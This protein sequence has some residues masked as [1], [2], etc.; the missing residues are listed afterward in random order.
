TLFSRCSK[1]LPNKLIASTRSDFSDG[2]ARTTRTH[3]YN[4]AV[5]TFLLSSV[6]VRT[7]V[8][9]SLISSATRSEFVPSTLN[10]RNNPTCKNG[11]L[12]PPTSYS[13]APAPNN[14]RNCRTIIGTNLRTFSKCSGSCCKISTTIAVI[15]SCTP[16]LL[17]P[18]N[19]RARF[20]NNSRLSG[21]R[22][23][24]RSPVSTAFLRI[25]DR[26]DPISLNTSSIK[27]RAISSVPRTDSFLRATAINDPT[28]V[29]IILGLTS[30]ISSGNKNIVAPS[31][32]AI[33]IAYFEFSLMSSSVTPIVTSA[34]STIPGFIPSSTS[35][36]NR[37][38]FSCESL[39]DRIGYSSSSACSPPSSSASKHGYVLNN[40]ATNAK[41]NLGFPLT[42]VFADTYRRHPIASAPSNIA[43]ALCVKSPILIAD[44]LHTSGLNW[45]SNTI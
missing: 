15:P 28:N 24:N 25:N 44:V 7:C 8:N 17:S 23:T 9:T 4:T 16:W 22:C 45:L 27:S 32:R 30:A 39:N 10:S 42:T 36:R 12:S 40:T 6:C 11:S 41:F 33:E 38:V 19:C 3:S 31:L 29:S 20:K 35:S 21:T 2:T 26:D 1:N 43:S 34:G 5:P 14:P 18:N 37:P 13:T